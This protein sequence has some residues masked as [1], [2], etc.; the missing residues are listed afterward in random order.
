MLFGTTKR[1]RRTSRDRRGLRVP[2]LPLRDIIVLPAHGGSLFVG[3]QSHPCLEEAMNKQKYI[4]LPRRGRQDQRP[5]RGDIY[6]VGTFVRWSSSPAS[7]RHREGAGRG[8]E[9]RAGPRYLGNPEFFR[10]DARRSRAD[11]KSTE[12]EALIRSVNTTFEN[13]VKLNKKIPRR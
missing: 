12:V 7:R 4:L 8:Q 13:Y 6:K 9:A 10:V 3:R 11:A 5:C 2:L 1:D